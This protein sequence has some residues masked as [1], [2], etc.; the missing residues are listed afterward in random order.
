MLTEDGSARRSGVIDAM[1]LPR[2]LLMQPTMICA[3]VKALARHEA[4]AARQVHAALRATDH[5]FGLGRLRTARRS[6]ELFLERLD[7]VI[8]DRKCDQKQDE[9]QRG[10][11]RVVIALVCPNARRASRAASRLSA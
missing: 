1:L 11:G 4:F 10:R 8:N 6:I 7:D 5:V 9:L 2:F 3:A